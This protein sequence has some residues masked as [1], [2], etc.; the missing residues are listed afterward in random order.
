MMTS[1]PRAACS[2]RL[3]NWSLAART[4]MSIDEGGS[5][6][7]PSFNNTGAP[8]LTGGY[9]NVF[10]FTTPMW[11]HVA[12]ISKIILIA[13]I[14]AANSSELPLP[15]SAKTPHALGTGTVRGPFSHTAVPC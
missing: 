2:S 5:H 7:A 6:T 12:T 13:D 9:L 8:V 3:D 14:A 15:G 10:L 11:P 4:L 1:L